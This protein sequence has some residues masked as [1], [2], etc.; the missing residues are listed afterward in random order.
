MDYILIY[1]LSFDWHLS[2]DKK[3]DVSVPIYI[4]HSV[5]TIILWGRYIIILRGETTEVQKDQRKKNIQNFPLV[6]VLIS[7]SQIVNDL[8][9]IHKMEYYYI[10]PLQIMDL[11]YI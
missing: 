5:S 3:T 6:Y 10:S 7:H 8:W 4:T 2:S 9:Y 1:D 11:K